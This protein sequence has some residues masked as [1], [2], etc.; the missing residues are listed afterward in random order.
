V[1]AARAAPPLRTALQELRLTFLLPYRARLQEARTLIT[2]LC[3]Q[4]AHSNN[5]SLCSQGAHSNGSL[6][7]QG[8]HSVYDA[9][10]DSFSVFV[11]YEKVRGSEGERVR[12]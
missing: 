11:R 4:G 10:S 1:H 5:G 12:G 2:A 3:S 6:C 9:S 8:A 7:S